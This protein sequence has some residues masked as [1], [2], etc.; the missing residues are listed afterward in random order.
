M[1]LPFQRFLSLLRADAMCLL[2]CSVLL[3]L[4][5]FLLRPAIPIIGAGGVSSG[6]DAYEKIRKGA[7]LVQLYTALGYEG[8]GIVPRVKDELAELLE[9]D[10]F[11]GVS[12]AVGIDSRLS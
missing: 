10:G 9:K 1:L 6:K 2:F 3:F 8:P 11:S 7:S 5:C 4:F 12:Q